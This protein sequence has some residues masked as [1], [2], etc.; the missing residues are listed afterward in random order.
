M[1]VGTGGVIMQEYVLLYE[2]CPDLYILR[3]FNT[4]LEEPID[5]VA[6]GH[7][8]HRILRRCTA[9]ECCISVNVKQEASLH[10]R[11]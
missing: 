5:G 11:W 8:F 10:K 9:A 6:A 4:N 3:I 2:A 1:A 7:L